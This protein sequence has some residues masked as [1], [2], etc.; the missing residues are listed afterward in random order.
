MG[1]PKWSALSICLACAIEPQASLVEVEGSLHRTLVT[2]ADFG[3]EEGQELPQGEAAKQWT[4][5]VETSGEVR[6]A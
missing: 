5:L 6:D 1:L 4:Q 3:W 2:D